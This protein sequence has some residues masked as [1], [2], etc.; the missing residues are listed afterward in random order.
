MAYSAK[1]EAFREAKYLWQIESDFV[2]FVI[3][4]SSPDTVFRAE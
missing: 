3:V 2:V 4:F 1:M